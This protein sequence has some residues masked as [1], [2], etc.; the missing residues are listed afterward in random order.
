LEAFARSNVDILSVTRHMSTKNQANR[1]VDELQHELSR[2]R[3]CQT[4]G[5][6]YILRQAG[7]D[8]DGALRALPISCHQGNITSDPNRMDDEQYIVRLIGQVITVSLETLN[9]VR[10]LTNLSFEGDE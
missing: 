1:S 7:Y 5:K 9:L 3:T 10:S 2:S 6:S 8:V 4:Y